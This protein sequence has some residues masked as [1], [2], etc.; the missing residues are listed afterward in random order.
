[1]AARTITKQTHLDS[2]HALSNVKALWVHS[3]PR[4][5]IFLIRVEDGV[6][7]RFVAW[8]IELFRTAFGHRSMHYLDRFTGTVMVFLAVCVVAFVLAKFVAYVCWMNPE[9]NRFQPRYA[10]PISVL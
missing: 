6:L 4:M 9:Q 1:M 7:R 2:G 8:I 3:D 5:P 10:L